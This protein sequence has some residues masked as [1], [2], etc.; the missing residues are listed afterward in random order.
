MNEN[1]RIT[2]LTQR[3]RSTLHGH[4]GVYQRNAGLDW[5]AENYSNAS[6]IVYF[7]DDDNTYDQRVYH[8]FS[9]IGK[10]GTILG[11]LQIDY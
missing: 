5:V 11:V 2:L 3:T 1:L 8:E 7:G 9:Q 4:R 10:K 6:A